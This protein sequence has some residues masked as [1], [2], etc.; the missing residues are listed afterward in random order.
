[1][2]ERRAYLGAML[3][4][5]CDMPNSQLKEG[6]LKFTEHHVNKSNW[7]LKSKISGHLGGSE[8]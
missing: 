3:Y 1:M 6:K 7:L 5:L 8:G 2:E 4:S